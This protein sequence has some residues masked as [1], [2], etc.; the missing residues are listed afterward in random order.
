MRQEGYGYAIIGGPGKQEQ[1]DF[2]SKTAGA[3]M[4]TG[5]ENSVYRDMLDGS[6]H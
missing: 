6:N 4:I 3:I 1:W 5:S 2:Y